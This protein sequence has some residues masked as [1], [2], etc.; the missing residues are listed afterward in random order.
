MFKFIKEVLINILTLD[1]LHLL[2]IIIGLIIL[3]CFVSVT[4]YIL[5]TNPLI[6]IAIVSLAIFIKLCL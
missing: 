2:R 3:F 4:I 6:F 1:V 5:I